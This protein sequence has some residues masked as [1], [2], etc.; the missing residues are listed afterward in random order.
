MTSPR[1]TRF[2]ARFFFNLLLATLL[3]ASLPAFADDDGHKI[4]GGYFE[5]WSIYFADF[6]LGHSMATSPPCSNSSNCIRI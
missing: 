1:F 6:T 2:P 4:V 5:E 3:T